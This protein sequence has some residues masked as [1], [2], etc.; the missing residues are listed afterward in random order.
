MQFYSLVSIA[1][2]K[3]CFKVQLFLKRILYNTLTTSKSKILQHLPY[4]FEYKSHFFVPKYHPKS[5]VRL[6]HEYMKCLV[7]H[8]RLFEVFP[9]YQFLRCLSIISLIAFHASSVALLM[10]SLFFHVLTRLVITY[11]NKSHCV[12]SL[13]TLIRC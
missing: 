12:A 11:P 9:C 3:F 4:L 5:Q 10:L 8:T 2:H 7:C 1:Y 13:A 6:I